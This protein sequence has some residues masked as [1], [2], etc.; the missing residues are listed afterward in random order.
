[1]IQVEPNAAFEAV[2]KFPTGLTGTLGVRLIDNVG[3]T[4]IN[5]ATAGITEYPA[6]SGIYQKTLTAPGTAGQYTIVWD[7]AAGH[8]APDDLLVTTEVTS[9][10]IGSGN[11]YVTREELKTILRLANESYADEAI[12]IAVEA[13]S[14]ACDGYKGKSTG[15]F[16]SSSEIRYY[17]AGPYDTAIDIDDAISISEVAI[18]LDGSGGYATIWTEG[19]QFILD[20]ANAVANGVPR[21]RLVLKTAGSFASI[22][23]PRDSL[24]MLVPTTS[25]PTYQRAI[26]VTAT[27]GWAAVP[28]GVKAAAILIARRLL[29]RWEDAPLGML[30]VQSG[31]AVALAALGAID[32]DAAFYLDNI[33]GASRRLFV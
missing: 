17:S 6:G 9:A 16:A 29:A 13:A 19:N 3:G 5:R 21:R 2:A 24:P 23:D 28:A 30:V 20:P 33:P 7:D 10:T 4:T 18:D 11:L 12:D 15:F 25:F 1:M 31:D 8:F 27:F 22:A 14:R 26:R 32:K